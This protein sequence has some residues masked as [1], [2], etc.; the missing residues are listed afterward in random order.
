LWSGERPD[1]QRRAAQRDN[2]EPLGCL[3][4]NA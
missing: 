3:L 4:D 1:G 2:A